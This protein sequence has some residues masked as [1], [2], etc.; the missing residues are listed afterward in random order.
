MKL[1]G[2]VQQAFL[3]GK[4][5]IVTKGGPW[6]NH[7][8][9]ST[10]L[11]NRLN[12]KCHIWV[13]GNSNI[14]TPMLDDAVNWN[15]N[16]LS[17]NRTEF[18]DETGILTYASEHNL[19]YVP[20]G[21]ADKT[22]V[23]Y[24]SR[25]MQQLALPVY[26]YAICAVGTATTF[27]GLSFVAENFCN[28]IGIDAGTNDLLVQQKIEQWQRD[29]PGKKLT[30][31]NEFSFGGFARHTPTLIRFMNELSATQQLPTDVVYTGKLMYAV[32]QLAE[33]NYFF[34]GATVLVIHSGGLQGNRSLPPGLLQF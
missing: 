31:M 20:M 22:G 34:T 21:G 17:I 5:G 3:E 16:L 23:E 1:K 11:C 24:V 7:I 25:F 2:F 13:K 12:L 9:A 32:H 27:G 33:K 18:Y 15:A 19:L 6:S 10:W 4:A 14:T 26:D 8:Y 29:L 30:L 28:V